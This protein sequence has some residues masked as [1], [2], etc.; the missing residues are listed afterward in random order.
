[1]QEAVNTSVEVPVDNLSAGYRIHHVSREHG[2]S[3]A[4]QEWL[5]NGLI[6]AFPDLKMA[7]YFAAKP[8]WFQEYDHLIY[9]SENAS[10]DIVGLLAARWVELEAGQDN[11]AA[12]F[13]HATTQFIV[14]RWQGTSMLR[15]I[16]REFLTLSTYGK[17]GFPE[18]I[19]LKT[20]NPLAFRPMRFF[21]R[22]AGIEVYPQIDGSPQIHAMAE[23]AKRIAASICPDREFDADTGVINDIS[24]PPDFYPRLPGGKPESSISYYFHTHLTC[25]DRMLCITHIKTARARRIVLDAFAVKAA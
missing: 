7:E 16:W 1:M 19:V 18:I 22:V 23:L 21:A 9:C 5:K 6:S 24:T 4:Q 20:C 3:T 10:G 11:P 17:H 25:R 13:L 14:P 12:R 8:N 2:F 15:N